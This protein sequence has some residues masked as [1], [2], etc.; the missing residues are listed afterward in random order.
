VA[1][2]LLNSLRFACLECQQNLYHRHDNSY[3]LSDIP[4]HL[5]EAIGP[6][7]RGMV[8]SDRMCSCDFLH[9]KG[10]VSVSFWFRFLFLFQFQVC[11][12]FGF[13]FGF[14]LV[15]VLVLVL[16]QFWNL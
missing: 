8:F 7:Y 5:D 9:L 15:L 3:H 4:T 6:P 2:V 13:G 1:V 12:C 11:F 10:L 14:V 16:V